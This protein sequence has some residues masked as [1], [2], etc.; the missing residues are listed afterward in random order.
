MNVI[1]QEYLREEKKGAA[2]YTIEIQHFHKK[3]AEAQV[4]GK[5]TT[6]KFYV[7]LSRFSIDLYIAGDSAKDDTAR[8]SLYLTNESDWMLRARVDVYV[9]KEIVRSTIK[10]GAVFQSKNAV[11][12]ERSSGWSTCILHSRCTNGDLLFPDGS[13]ILTVKVVEVLTEISNRGP[14]LSII[15]EQLTDLKHKLESQETEVKNLKTKLRKVETELQNV[16]V[17]ADPLSSVNTFKCPGCTKVIKK[18]MRL[19]QCLNGHIICESC[20]QHLRSTAR[21]VHCVTCQ[22]IYIGRPRALE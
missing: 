4:G 5:V 7:N 3:L 11:M 2:S 16:E 8:I 19:Q 17:S 1:S 21:E 10:A 9:K 22:A 15:Q 6:K 18:P 20:H 14:D 12:S 13:L